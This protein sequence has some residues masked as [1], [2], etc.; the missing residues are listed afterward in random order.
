MTD[1]DDAGTLGTPIYDRLQQDFA[2]GL[3]GPL[4]EVAY[5]D[6]Q[7]CDPKEAGSSPEEPPPGVAAHSLQPGAQ[8]SD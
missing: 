1:T 4:P 2:D 5:A 6:E 8:P 7:R 3:A